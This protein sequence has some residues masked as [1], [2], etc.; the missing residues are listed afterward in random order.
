[1]SPFSRPPKP[2]IGEDDEIKQEIFD[3]QKILR[4]GMM[5]ITLMLEWLIA[6]PTTWGAIIIRCFTANTPAEFLASIG[7]EGE[8]EQRNAL[9]GPI[10]TDPKWKGHLQDLWQWGVVHKITKDCKNP[11]PVKSYVRYVGVRKGL[12]PWM[13]AITSCRLFNLLVGRPPRFG[14]IT[15]HILVDLIANFA[16]P[17]MAT[18]DYKNHFYQILLPK[19]ARGFFII[20]CDGEEYIF[21]DV[22]MGF[23]W[24]PF[25]AEGLTMVVLY[26]AR[27]EWAKDNKAGDQPVIPTDMF[28]DYIV[29]TR[30]N[31]T[32]AYLTAVYDNLFVIAGDKATRDGLR[33]KINAMNRK[34]N[35]LP[36]DQTK[37]G[38]DPQGWFVNE[39]PPADFPPLPDGVEGKTFRCKADRNGE[40][41]EVPA[42]LRGIIYLGVDYVTVKVGIGFRHTLENIKA[43]RA[44]FEAMLKQICQLGGFVS[45][46]NVAELTGVLVWDVRICLKPLSVIGPILRMMSEIGVKM[47]GK[48]GQAWDT[49]TLLPPDDITTLFTT[50]ANFLERVEK[51]ELIPWKKREAR[52]K[53]RYYLVSDSSK[54]LGSGLVLK[55][56]KGDF[57]HLIQ[58]DWEK[59]GMLKDHI[60]W[61]ETRVAI[62]LIKAVIPHIPKAERLDSEIIFGEDNTTTVAALNGLHYAKDS[63]ICFELLGLFKELDGISLVSYW[64]ST[65]KMPADEPTRLRAILRG[66]CG[67]CYEYLK[68]CY[69]DRGGHTFN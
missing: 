27:E 20:L 57:E 54:K 10:N 21:L 44:E 61:K 66:K 37:D 9:V 63:A 5:Y 58:I 56:D 34:F 68:K 35:I 42:H 45:D 43:W 33:G 48:S 22:C 40:Q 69:E 39:K 2:P 30:N 4:A 14:L 18:C 3:L 25:W 26:A 23:S 65:D 19:G 38:A 62:R 16:D 7:V 51:G 29:V 32:V 64:V 67:Q 59:E 55:D 31:K 52:K 8:E 15:H 53:H 41:R 28:E 60:N 36:K 46:R 50:Y 49:Q 47:A 11:T 17:W 24:S 13:R 6:H 12:T 1:M